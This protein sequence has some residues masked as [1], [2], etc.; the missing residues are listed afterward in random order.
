MTPLPFLRSPLP[1][2]LLC[3]LILTSTSFAADRKSRAAKPSPQADKKRRGDSKSTKGKESVASNKRSDKRDKS[4]ERA[5]KNAKRDAKDRDTG[6]L[7]RRERRAADRRESARREAERREA[8]RRR[9]EEEARRAELARQAR[10]AAIARARAAEQAL[11]D[12]T[13]ANI[14]A[15]D[16]TGEDPEVRRAAV[17]A[18]GNLAGTVV[19]MDPMSGRVYTIVNQDWGVRRGFKPC[20]TIKLVTGLAG[21]EDKVIAP[22]ETVAAWNGRYR[23]DLTDSLA[24]SNNTYFQRIGGQVGF[25]R[26]LATAREV[27]LGQPTGVNHARESAGRV[28]LFK[29]GYAVNH[30]S[31]HGDDFKVTP[32]Q[33]AL[34][35]SA[36]ANGGNLLVPHLPRTPEENEFFRAEMRRRLNVQPESLRRLVPGMIGAVNYGS[37]RTAYDATQTIGGKT[38]S[39]IDDGTWVGL[40][41][42]YAPVNDPRLA[43]AV[44][45]KGAGARGKVAA[46]V[47]GRVYRALNHRFGSRGGV[48]SQLANLPVRPKLDAAAARAVSDE[49]R[50][51]E[52]AALGADP[53]APAGDSS[54][55]SAQG[56]QRVL[57]AMPTTRPVETTT[58]PDTS[59][60]S[61]SPSSPNYAPQAG[62][63]RRVLST[64]P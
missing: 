58:R 41:T 13:A 12:A 49:D 10:L 31:S 38:G 43:V 1:L 22:T 11:R 62:R 21:I 27:G 18:L 51:V 61:V 50:E 29:T 64:S 17:A 33:L 37:G 56:M 15:D 20:S 3:L 32:M 55:G 57:K 44:V 8:E 28:P 47:A 54:K 6:K 25:D 52:E 39:C 9:R 36:I 24:Y 5:A 14:A 7:S 23:L 4:E 26:M 48:P 46:G 63:P 2:L 42:S 45:V 60:S 59:N 53:N 16:M 34:M 30:M 35:A 40:F 19:V